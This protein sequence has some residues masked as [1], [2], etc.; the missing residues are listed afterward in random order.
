[1]FTVWWNCVTEDTADEAFADKARTLKT[2]LDDL[3][4]KKIACQA[5]IKKLVD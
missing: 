3:K 5:A 4:L 1:M 2:N